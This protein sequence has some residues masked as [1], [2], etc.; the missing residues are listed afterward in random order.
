MTL[1][2]NKP[3]SIEAVQRLMLYDVCHMYLLYE[4]SV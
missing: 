4:N 1:F 2:C 3:K